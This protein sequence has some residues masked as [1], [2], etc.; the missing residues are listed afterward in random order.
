MIAIGAGVAIGAGLGENARAALVTRG[1]AEIARL[2]VALGG[3]AETVA[4]LS[5]MGDLMLT[6]AGAASRNYRLG[7]AIGGGA[8]PQAALAGMQAA[9]EG[10]LAAPG[11]LARSHGDS[12]VIHAVARLLAGEDDVA[13]AMARL[14]ARP[15]GRSRRALTKQRPRALPLDPVKGRAFE[16]QLFWLYSRILCVSV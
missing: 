16:I 13:A 8:A 14:L 2:A 1:L 10:V 11:L 4:G 7:L 6:C 5:G 12:P 3:R 15:G 9:V